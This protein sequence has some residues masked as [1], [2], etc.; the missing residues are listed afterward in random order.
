M[1]LIV[2]HGLA[3]SLNTSTETWL[4]TG[5]E[6][7][8]KLILL[9]IPV[10]IVFVYL[11]MQRGLKALSYGTQTTATVTD[12]TLHRRH[13]RSKPHYVLDW[14]DA[15]GY[16]GSSLPAKISDFDGYR[17]G[18]TITVYRN[19]QH[20]SWWERDVTGRSAHAFE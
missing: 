2:V 18:V 20:D 15:D 12:F 14:V 3:E 4:F 16:V 9:M 6:T 5:V 13:R 11:K 17:R 19:S 7:L 10:A 8:I 1:F